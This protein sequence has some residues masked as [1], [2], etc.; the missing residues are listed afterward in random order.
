MI[1]FTSHYKKVLTAAAL[2]LSIY[3]ANAQSDA[4]T[5]IKAGTGDANT[6]FNAYAGPLMKG[7]GAGLNSGWFQTAKPHGMGG[8]DFTISTNV[9]FA[10]SADQS[11][12]VNSLGLQK[13]RLQAGQESKAPTVFGENSNGPTV[14]IVD[15]SPIT[16]N[17]TAYTSMTLPPGIGVNF[18]AVPTAQLAVGVGYGTEIAVRFVPNLTIGDI[19]VGM[20]GFA[21]KHDVKQWIPGM[22][23]MPFDLSVM[24]G[25]TTVTTDVKFAGDKAIKPDV[26]SDGSQNPNIDY[27]TASNNYSGQKME[28]KSKGWTTNVIVSKKLGPF[29]PYLGLGYQNSTTDLSIIG[30]YPVTV[31]CTPSEFLANGNKVAKISDV[32]D[33]VKVSGSLSGFRSTLGFRLKFA[34]LTI[35]GDYTFAQY[36]VASLG[37]GLNL[38][39]IVPFKM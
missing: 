35:H 11:F 36:N 14:E 20:F 12:D 31:P 15:K 1:N 30:N 5:L 25:Y 13:V 8:F 17:D 3:Q 34:V 23:E 4:A 22:K 7:F 29:T 9:P 2:S 10:P 19:G 21:V 27:S 26:N 32:T 33:P 24:F 16:G 37:I 28:F 6:L 38:Q 18:A 39:S